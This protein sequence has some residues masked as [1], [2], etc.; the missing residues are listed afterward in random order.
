MEET[1][2]QR[3]FKEEMEEA[4][5]GERERERHKSAPSSGDGKGERTRTQR[6]PADGQLVGARQGRVAPPGQ[7]DGGRDKG[8]DE[9]A[10]GAQNHGQR[11]RVG[12]ISRDDGVLRE[13]RV[14]L[15]HGRFVFSPRE[16][17]K[18]EVEVEVKLRWR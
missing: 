9:A 8:A 12:R 17:V 5:W 3:T 1:E 7:G 4:A 10:K 18:V 15:R 13:I 11:R 14:V 6:K 16:L 2:R